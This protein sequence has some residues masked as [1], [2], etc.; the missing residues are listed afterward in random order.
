MILSFS[1]ENYKS[2]REKSTISFEATADK[3]DESIHTVP[4]GDTKILRMAAL[5]GPNASGKTN[6]LHALSFLMNFIVESATKIKPNAPIWGA[7]KISN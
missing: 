3:T 5:F 6:M 1:V 2:I 4:F 7:F